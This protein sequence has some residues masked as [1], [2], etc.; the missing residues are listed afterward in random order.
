MF[1]QKCIFSKKKKKQQYITSPYKKNPEEK[2]SIE[3]I[4]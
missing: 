3:E 1:D 4:L 2:V